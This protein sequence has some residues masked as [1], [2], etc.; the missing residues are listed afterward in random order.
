MT[1]TELALTIKRMRDLQELSRKAP[2]SQERRTAA[3][4]Y[5]LRIDNLIRLILADED[6]N[7]IHLP[8]K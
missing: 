1:L 7:N 3:A 8:F 6:S 4:R 5:E 2:Q